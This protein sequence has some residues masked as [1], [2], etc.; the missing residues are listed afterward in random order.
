MSREVKRVPLDFD[1][2]L[3]ERWHGYLMPEQLR[4]TR[5]AACD[6]SGWSPFAKMMQDVWYGYLPFRPEMTGSTPLTSHSPA[7]RV[8]AERNVAAA[9]DFY[10]TGVWAV[11]REARR[12][13][14]FFNSAWSHHLDAGDVEA[15]LEHDRLWDFTR[16]W[17][18]ER[19][20][21]RVLGGRPPTPAE[22]NEWSLS[23]MGHDST[24]AWACIRAR[25]RREG[26]PDTCY[27]CDGNGSFEVYAGQRDDA[28]AW[29]RTDPPTGDG[30]QLWETTTEGSPISPV[31][32][33]AE[34]LAGWI[35]RP[36][37]TDRYAKDWLPP[38][39]AMQFVRA[40]W[41]PTGF[42][43]GGLVEPASGMEVIGMMEMAEDAAG[44]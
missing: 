39:G 18:R 4:E 33:T 41:A 24:N 30:W 26:V 23:G 21:Q 2:P 44:G 11:E 32:A 1:W 19:R 37:R 22:V 14:A 17:S 10:G 7:V 8:R 27:F 38:A 12:L 5:C 28:D 16:H 34:E 29:T 40:G 35:S 31:F 3:Y 20:W 9:P 6:G 15:L 36:D 42:S 13:A 25:C 43:G